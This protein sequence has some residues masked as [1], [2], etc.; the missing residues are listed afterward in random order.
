MGTQAQTGRTT[1]QLNAFLRGE[2]S[3]LES[4]RRALEKIDADSPLREELVSCRASHE[5]RAHMLLRTIEIL[6]GEPTGPPESVDESPSPAI[7]AT[8][9]ALELGEELRLR[10]YETDLDKLEGEARLLVAAEVLPAQ[11]Q[12]YRTLAELRRITR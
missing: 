6:G 10:S 2:L 4:Y 5:Q 11:E 12:T 9:E 7:E 8:I 3:A 1:E